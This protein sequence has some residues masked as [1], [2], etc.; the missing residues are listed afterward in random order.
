MLLRCYAKF[1]SSLTEC[2]AEDYYKA[3]IAP[4]LNNPPGMSVY[5]VKR[6]DALEALLCHKAAYT[7]RPPKFV[8]GIDVSSVRS[9]AE[10]EAVPNCKFAFLNDTHG[11]IWFASQDEAL[12]FTR[13]LK[14]DL[15]AG[16]TEEVSAEADEIRRHLRRRGMAQDSEW[17]KFLSANPKWMNEARLASATPVHTPQAE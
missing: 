12:E 13:K 5:A 7:D 14:A 1:K 11:V 3:E 8:R 9:D 17:G 4:R 15:E 6:E 10:P 16:R 2:S